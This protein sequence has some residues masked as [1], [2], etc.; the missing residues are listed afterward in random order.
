[1]FLDVL[2]HFLPTTQ[3]LLKEKLT[4]PT[5]QKKSKSRFSSNV[6]PLYKYFTY[7]RQK[8]KSIV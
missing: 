3:S 4:A 8:T 5:K 7:C 1:M 2:N 6:M